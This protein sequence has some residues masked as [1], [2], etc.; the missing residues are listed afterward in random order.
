MAVKRLEVLMPGSQKQFLNEVNHLMSLNHPNIVRCTG[1]CYETQNL[2]LKYDGIPIFAETAERL[3]CLEYM[4]NGSL[5]KHLSGM[6]VHDMTYV[7][8]KIKKKTTFLDIAICVVC[9]HSY[10]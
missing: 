9:K 4:P 3:L 10:Y 8:S 5:D 7:V 6:T 2:F 1:Y